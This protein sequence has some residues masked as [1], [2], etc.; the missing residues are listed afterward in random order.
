MD[1]GMLEVGH[2]S[3]SNNIDTPL[4]KL[5]NKWDI[6]TTTEQLNMNL[7]SEE[8]LIL[9]DTLPE[10]DSIL[11]KAQILNNKTQNRISRESVARRQN[12]LGDLTTYGDVTGDGVVNIG[13]ALRIAQFVVN[14]PGLDFTRIAEFGDVTGDGLVNIGDALRIAQVQVELV[15]PTTN[16]PYELAPLPVLESK[17]LSLV[18]NGDNLDLVFTGSNLVEHDKSISGLQLCV[19]GVQLKTRTSD[20]QGYYTSGVAASKGWIV[21]SNT[22]SSEENLSI[23]YLE[24]DAETKLLQTDNGVLCSFET[25]AIGS[26]QIV[27]S[28]TAN[29]K[30]YNSFVV[31]I[32]SNAEIQTYTLNLF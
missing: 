4:L 32:N 1:S 30:T 14:L 21:A 26:P 23:M 7:N 19:S 17:L 12:K 29:S 6:S 10:D 28:I 5:K 22:I 18:Q 13:D 2:A 8:Q 20:N 24:S 25:N 16:E 27:D 11:R 15:N 3:V 31:D 9:E